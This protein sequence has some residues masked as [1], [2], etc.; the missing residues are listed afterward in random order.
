MLYGLLLDRFELK[1]HTENREVTVYALTVAA[2][3]PK[4]TQAVES[5]R[6]NCG[7]DANAPQPVPN[8]GPMMGC[9]NTSMAELAQ[10]LSRWAS[11]YIDHPIVDATGL[12]G[13]W[14]FFIGWTPRKLLDKAQ[15]GNQT[16]PSS[17]ESAMASDPGGGLSVFQAL[18]KELGLKLVKQT[19]SI[20]VTVVDHVDEKPIE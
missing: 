11:A 13:G 16:A 15:P 2:G 12:E 1:T 6:S 20:P 8:L 5:E 10:N 7:P 17:P 3:K 9:K 14:D 18:E 19:R 4:V